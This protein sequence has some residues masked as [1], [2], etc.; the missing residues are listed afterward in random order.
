MNK[1]GL[2]LMK[3]FGKNS[4]KVIIDVLKLFYRKKFNIYNT[5]NLSTIIKYVSIKKMNLVDVCLLLNYIKYYSKII[6]SN[7]IIIHLI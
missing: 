7:F 3:M 4:K 2:E 5:Y 6:L 1:N